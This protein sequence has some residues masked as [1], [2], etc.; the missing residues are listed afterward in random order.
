MTDGNTSPKADCTVYIGRDCV[1]QFDAS[2]SDSNRSAF[3]CAC[4]KT[5]FISEDAGTGA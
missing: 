1:K 3:T 5:E 2:Q 4:G